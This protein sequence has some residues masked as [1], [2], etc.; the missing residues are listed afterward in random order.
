MLLEGKK[1]AEA[2]Y[3]NLLLEISLLP[4]IP[5]LSVVLV[6]NDPASETYV[7]SKTKRCLTLGL[8]GDT[9]K[10]SDQISEQEL[11]ST[12]QKLNDDD[13]VQ[14]ILVQLPL[15]KHI[16]KFK[17]IEAIHPLK[18][19]DGLHPENQGRL[20]LGR[21]RVAPCTPAGVIQI[22]KH[23][24]IPIAGK[25]VVIVG[26][27]EI[28][29]KPAAQLFLLEDATVTVCHSKTQDLKKETSQA[30]I[31]V[32]ALGQP[33]FIQ[34]DFIKPQAVV[35]DVGIHRI[36]GKIVGDVHF[37]SVSTKASAITPVPGGVGPM[38]IAM[39]MK[40]LVHLTQLQS[41]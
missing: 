16:N 39:L 23:Y 41:S 37:E 9:L 6:G 20:L 35:V 28:V 34:A 11:L 8:R 17:I 27:S 40:N 12:I 13:E 22:L 30:D 4:K 5:K 19:V 18:D 7:G 3:S 26:R 38:T 32:A 36:N 21:P 29:G 25:K 24:Q 1:V 15:P 33:Q 31:L 2:V 10:L 14:G